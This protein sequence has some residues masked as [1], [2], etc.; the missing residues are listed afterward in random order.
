M[1]SSESD[2]SS[3]GEFFFKMVESSAKLAQSYH[4][5]YMDKAPPRFMFSQQS[6][7]GG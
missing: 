7:M 1:S 5:L 3:D 6:G 4:D 2:D